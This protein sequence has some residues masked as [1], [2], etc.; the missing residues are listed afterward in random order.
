MSEAFE[1]LDP[2][3][4]RDRDM[5]LHLAERRA[6][7][8]VQGHVPVYS[9]EIRVTSEPNVVAGF[10]RF[11]AANTPFLA[12]YAG[13]FGYGVEERFRG[14]HLA[15][16]ATRLLF[17]LARRHGF[18]TLW[19]TCNPENHAS[20]RTIERLGGVFVEIVP[21]PVDTD[22]YRKGA[23]EKCRYRIDL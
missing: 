19:I 1:F 23:V 16:R 9:F 20:R 15:E 7:D 5:F 13:H 6:A 17:P 21:V 3:E 8:A 11:R 14:N 18:L 4:L 12:R 10:V 2:G 22:M